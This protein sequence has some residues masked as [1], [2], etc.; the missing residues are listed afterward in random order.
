V[1]T[2]TIKAIIERL[3]ED[4]EVDWGEDDDRDE[5]WLSWVTRRW[6]K[7]AQGIEN[8]KKRDVPKAHIEDDC[9]D[10]FKWEFGDF[11]IPDGGDEGDD[12]DDD[13]PEPPDP[14]WYNT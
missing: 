10:C 11:K 2:H 1:R 6:R 7:S 13:I 14:G 12:D 8:H 3:L 4:E 9:I 5:G